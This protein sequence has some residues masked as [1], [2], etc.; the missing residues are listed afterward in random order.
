MVTCIIIDDQK[1]AVKLLTNQ[2]NSIKKLQLLQAFTSP[3]KALDFLKKTAIDLVFIEAKLSHLNGLEFIETIKKQLVNEPNFI[4][5]TRCDKYAFLGFEYGVI[6]YLLKPVGI[7]RFKI[8]MDRYFSRRPLNDS[9]T[10]DRGDYF[11]ADSNG[12]KQK[13]NFKDISFVESAGNYALIYGDNNLKMLI[14]KS[15]NAIQ[16]ILPAKNFIRVHKSYIV[17]V[18]HIQAIK[19]NELIVQRNGTMVNISIGRTFKRFILKKLNI[20]C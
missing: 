10:I 16:E 1:D 17:S 20:G 14:Y 19:G 2:I 6:D 5:T 11:F 18:N 7:N 12:V 9:S 3:L 13:I 8:S 15:L 4:L